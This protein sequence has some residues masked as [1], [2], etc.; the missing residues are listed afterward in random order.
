MALIKCPECG[1]SVSNKAKTCPNCGFAVSEA[2][3]DLIRIK[4][5]RDPSCGW[6]Q[7]RIFKTEGHELLATVRAGS[8][9]EIRST[10]EIKIQFQGLTNWPMCFATVS[11]KN[12][13]KY[14]AVW[15]A[16]IFSPTI[17]SCFA[18]DEIDF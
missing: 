6:T 5:D 16:G 12:G 10:K 7:V 4:V 11:P 13:G 8:V 9:A 17:T 18:V 2:A 3:N 14:R 15:G 1:K